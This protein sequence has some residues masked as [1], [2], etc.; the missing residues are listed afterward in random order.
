MLR[1]SDFVAEKK[2]FYNL[3][4]GLCISASKPVGRWNLERTSD[5]SKDN[6]LILS[7]LRSFWDL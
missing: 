4:R 7:R 3:S 2:R 1:L 5:T 6:L